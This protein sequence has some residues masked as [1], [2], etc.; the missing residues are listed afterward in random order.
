M[1]LWLAGSSE[2]TSGRDMESSLEGLVDPQNSICLQS[3]VVD[4]DI[5]Q[6]VRQRLSDDKGL[7]EWGKDVLLRKE[8]E[9][10]LMEGSK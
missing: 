3:E 5:Q 2:R 6:Y 1:R 4:K 10:A 7:S 8:I 9:S